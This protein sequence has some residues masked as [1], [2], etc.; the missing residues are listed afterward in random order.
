[1]DIQRPLP[2]EPHIVV[3]IH[4][5]KDEHIEDEEQAYLYACFGKAVV[6]SR[7]GAKI[8][9]RLELLLYYF[10]GLYSAARIDHHII[11]AVWLV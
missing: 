10:S 8:S 6:H 3:H 11:D 4:P 5:W 1:M 9:N 2:P 7:A